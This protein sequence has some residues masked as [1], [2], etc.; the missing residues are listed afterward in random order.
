MKD[1]TLTKR[2]QQVFGNPNRL[3]KVRDYKKLIQK[4]VSTISQYE[5]REVYEY[6]LGDPHTVI[7]GFLEKD[8]TFSV[9]FPGYQEKHFQ[10]VNIGMQIEILL[11][12]LENRWKVSND[13]DLSAQ[14]LM[15]FA[16]WLYVL[17]HTK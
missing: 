3:Q 16:N 4:Q 12:E 15:H 7:R 10:N 6:C 1:L 14:A 8:G 11:A 9:R 17:D 2:A 13:S 5:A